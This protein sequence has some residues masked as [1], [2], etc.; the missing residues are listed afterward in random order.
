ME[1]AVRRG[2]AALTA[3]ACRGPGTC[4]IA[5][6]EASPARANAA[7]SGFMRTNLGMVTF[8]T[9]FRFVGNTGRPLFLF[10]I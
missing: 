4:G 6:G 5:A 3:R 10:V 1:R 2:G 7:D 8:L 9:Y